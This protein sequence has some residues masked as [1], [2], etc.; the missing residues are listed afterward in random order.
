MTAATPGRTLKPGATA[1][2][3]GDVFDLQSQEDANVLVGA[4]FFV[5]GS[6]AG[7]KVFYELYQNW[8]PMSERFSVI[9]KRDGV[10]TAVSIFSDRERCERAAAAWTA[11][12]GH[13]KATIAR[14][15]LPERT[16]VSIRDSNM[17]PS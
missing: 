9:F 14:L 5:H 11:R 16:V 13:R 8:K 3:Q 7:D 1:N 10:Q 12:G 15:E 6:N 4:Q 17:N 2:D